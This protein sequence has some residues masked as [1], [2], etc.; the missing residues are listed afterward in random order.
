[1]F[2]VIGGGVA[3]TET[4]DLAAA[5]PVT[6][7]IGP[8]LLGGSGLI[9]EALVAGERCALWFDEQQWCQWVAPLLPAP[10]WREV[11]KDL[12]G[13]LA[14][15]TLEPLAVFSERYGLGNACAVEIGYER[16]ESVSAPVVHFNSRTSRL[17]AR[18]VAAPHGWLRHLSVRMDHLEYESLISVVDVAVCIGWVRID[19]KELDSLDQ[20]CCV[21]LD[22]HT[23]FEKGE[24]LLCEQGLLATASL[25]ESRAFWT[26]DSISDVCARGSH[27]GTSE[28]VGGWPL[29]CG[30]SGVGERRGDG[31]VQT[32]DGKMGIDVTVVMTAEVARIPLDLEKLKCLHPGMLLETAVPVSNGVRLCI[33]GQQVATGQLVNLGGRLGVL[34][35]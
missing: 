7:G 35:D 6:L 29:D 21:V 27:I 30:V 19:M 22:R 13:V 34:I 28:Q 3:S 33:N 31:F 25:D 9:L 10:S 16:V 1:M 26:I 32:E 4:Y 20:N 5:G 23:D 18:V 15:W 14:A 2:S 11:P 8:G 24:F 17:D 12:A